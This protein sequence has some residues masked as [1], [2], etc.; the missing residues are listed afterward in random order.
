[1]NST[2]SDQTFC[3]LSKWTAYAIG[4]VAA[5]TLTVKHDPQGVH[6]IPLAKLFVQAAQIGAVEQNKTGKPDTLDNSNKKQ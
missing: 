4:L 1:M 2:K 6:L 5:F 3:R